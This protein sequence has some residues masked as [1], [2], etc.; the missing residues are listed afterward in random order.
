MKSTSAISTQASLHAPLFPSERKILPAKTEMASQFLSTAEAA[1]MLGLSTTLIQTLVDNDELK[2]WKTRGG[3]RRI[4]IQSVM[5]Y[6]S[7]SGRKSSIAHRPTGTPRVMV[8]VETPDLMASLQKNYRQ[9]NFPLEVSFMDSVTEALLCFSTQVPDM[10]VA[11]LNMP[12][13][14][15][16]KTIQ[17]L[18]NYNEREKNGMSMVLVTPEKDLFANNNRLS[19]SMVQLVAGPLT[20]TWFHAYLTGVSTTC[21]V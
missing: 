2:G 6:Q 5:D 1:R 13:A 21:R 3:H 10:L 9:W 11:E 12:R 19:Q 8:V 20:P 15:Q 14:Q 16:E 4:A 7:Q 18:L 17:A